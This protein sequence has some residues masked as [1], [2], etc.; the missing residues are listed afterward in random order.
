MK[1]F[2]AICSFCHLRTAYVRQSFDQGS[3]IDCV[4][5]DV[6]KVFYKVSHEQLILKHG[7]LNLEPKVLT[8]IK[9]FLT[10]CLQFVRVNGNNH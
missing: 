4:F 10:K 1:D 7:N 8:H 6:S 9:E 2:R 3:Q 5:L